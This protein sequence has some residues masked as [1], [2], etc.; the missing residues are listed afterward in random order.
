MLRCRLT[1]A[2]QTFD[3]TPAYE[4]VFQVETGTVEEYLQQVHEMTVI[5]AIQVLSW[6]AALLGLEAHAT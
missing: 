1:Q 6:P 5:T 2:L 3:L 4:D